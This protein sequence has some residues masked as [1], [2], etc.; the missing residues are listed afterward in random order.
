MIEM[1]IVKI[2]SVRRLDNAVNYITKDRKTNEKLTTTYECDRHYIKEDFER[3][4]QER[5]L[6]TKRNSVQK[7]K[8]IIQS[9][10]VEDNV[11]PELA[12]KAGKELADNYLEGKHQY[13][14][15]T[16][17]DGN[18]I[19]NHI[20]FNEIRLDNLLMFD[21]TRINTIDNLRL[22]NDKISKKYDLYIPKE[23]AHENKIHYINQR[24]MSVRQKGISFKKR[25]ENTIDEAIEVSKD[26]EEF[27]ELMETKGY[28][29]KEGKHLAFENPDKN[30]F[31]RTKTLGIHYTENSIKYR[32]EN[33]D[34]KIHKYKYTL[35]TEKID[36][37]Q[38][39][40]RDNYG[41]RKWATKKNIAHLQEISNLVFNKGMTLEEIENINK[42]EQEFINDIQRTLSD[43]DS[44]I[45]DLQKKIGSFED[46]KNSAGLMVALRNAEDK[47]QFKSEN[48]KDII[49]HDIAKKNITQLKNEYGI[50]NASELSYLIKELESERNNLYKHFTELQKNRIKK[51]E[52]EQEKDKKH[53]RRM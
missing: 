16:H 14:L 44:T 39:K 43:K 15:T 13:I 35:E 1:S 3:I 11:T 10:G 48:Y 37:S 33:K 2:Q 4:L 50:T 23:R 12:H 49:K 40:F 29:H 53:H 7:S 19:H 25:L 22:E 20:I 28:K 9:F 6:K 26:Y 21:T 17:L 30:Y 42:T 45:Y 24:E 32:I 8:M 52:K 5:N 31:M 27:L 47:K 46:Y 18:H 36:K 41:L 51:K 34:F 38:E